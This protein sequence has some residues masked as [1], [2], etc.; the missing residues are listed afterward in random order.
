[1]QGVQPNL[2]GLQTS[3]PDQR[4]EG[5]QQLAKA[6]WLSHPETIKLIKDIDARINNL[7]DIITRNACDAACTDAQVRLAS[8]QLKCEMNVRAMLQLQLQN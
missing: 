7:T 1:M 6:Q 4:I 5:A 2:P 3:T 8:I